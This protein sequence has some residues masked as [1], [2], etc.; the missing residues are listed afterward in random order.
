VAIPCPRPHG[1]WLPARCAG[2]GASRTGC[3]TS[4]TS[5]SPRTLPASAPALDP[6]SWPRHRRPPQSRPHQ[7]RR[8]PALGQLQ[9]QPPTHPARLT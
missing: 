2:I 5:P 7:H 1:N 6:A 4:A 8:M 9:L 3:T